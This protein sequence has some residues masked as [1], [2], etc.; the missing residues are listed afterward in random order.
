M[1]ESLDEG[2]L[3]SFVGFGGIAKILVGN[4]KRPA[5]VRGHEIGEAIARGVGVAALDEA[6]NLDRES[7]YRQTRAIRGERGGRRRSGP[8]RGASRRDAR[9]GVHS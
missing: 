1:A 6:A 4:P 7:A 5:L 2:V 3:H 8:D 9:F